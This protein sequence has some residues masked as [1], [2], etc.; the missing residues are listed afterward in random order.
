MH[1]PVLLREV[2]MDFLEGKVVRHSWMEIRFLKL[3]RFQDL[4]EERFRVKGSRHC[5]VFYGI[6]S[7]MQ[8]T[9]VTNWAIILSTPRKRSGSGNPN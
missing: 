4:E 6:N 3:Q 7:H 9:Q 5:D 2:S 1:S 8:H